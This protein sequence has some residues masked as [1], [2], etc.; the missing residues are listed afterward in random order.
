MTMMFDGGIV[1]PMIEDAA[2]TA[3]AK[4]LSYPSSTIAGMSI[5]PIAA[6]SLTAAPVIP[7]KKTDARIFAC[8]S[9]P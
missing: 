6:V 2:V 7:A 9:P 3:A 1:G 8:A 5:D 4:G